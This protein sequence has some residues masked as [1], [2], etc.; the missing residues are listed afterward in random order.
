MIRV[1]RRV[2]P[3][4]AAFLAAAMSISGSAAP[5]AFGPGDLRALVALASPAISPDGARAVVVVGRIRWDEDKT[6]RELDLV[7]LRTHAHRAL[8]QDRT[9]LGDPAWSPDGTRLA[10]LADAGEGEDAHAQIY[11]MPMDGG[12]AR[13]IT[14]A[15]EGV[16]QFA[17]R[18]D[19]K[20]FAYAASDADPKKHGAAR[21][22][23]AFVFTTEPITERSAPKPMHLFEIAAEGGRA[24]QLTRGSASVAAGEAASTLSWSPDGASI[25]FLLAP[26]AILNDADRAHVAV[27]EVATKAVRA[28]TG[29][30]GYDSDPRYAPDGAHLLYLHSTGDTQVNPVEVYVAPAAG[31][32]GTPISHAYDRAASSAVWEPDGHALL[33][34][35]HDGTA[36]ALVRA[37][38][39]GATPE[40]V[41]LNGLS[42]TSSL[43]GA[44]AHDG[45]FVFVGSST[46]QPAELYVRVPGTPPVQ[47]TEDNAA[48]AARGLAH[49]ES[50]DFPTSLGPHGDAVLT[51]PVGYAE[52]HH[53]PLLVYIH[54]GP[55]SASLRVFDRFA[56]LAAARGWLVLQPNYR[57]SDNLGIAYQRGVLYDPEEGPG[58]DI[59]AAVDAVRARG[60]VDDHRIGVFGWSY[61][62]IMT[63]WMI[64]KY[65][66]WRAAVSGASV[67]DWATDY[68]VADDSDEDAALFHGSPYVRGNRAEWDRASAITYVHDVT[69]PVLILSDVGDNR[70][71][72]ATSSMY[73]RAL[74]DNHKDATLV[75]YP[76]DG[77]FPSD[78]VRAADI[79]GRTLAF[80]AAHFR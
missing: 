35:C 56:Q 57:G 55:T 1:P 74:R 32:A 16:E 36:N 77:H 8:T 11:V 34:V 51:Y 70:D 7:D 25:T 45:T 58:R 64:S 49:A 76:I 38:L 39:D 30:A 63:A 31:G 52:G 79:F 29:H 2:V 41:E 43:A 13:A 61:G 42:I 18:P 72:F 5:R 46:T 26:N 21:F 10:F 22:R 12:D 78:P 37:P 69:T 73:W 19:G 27:V 44:I 24:T 50:F 14:H 33:F 47:V 59:M 40:R 60:I 53:Y 54:G 20:A 65:H 15:P 67:N 3:L 66:L 80:I 62:G 68:G 71:P 17:W 75:A 23:D 6:E 28:P 48:I 4:A 9:G